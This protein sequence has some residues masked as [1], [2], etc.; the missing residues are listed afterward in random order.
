VTLKIATAF[1]LGSLMFPLAAHAQT[2]AFENIDRLEARLVA[3]LDADIGA[4]GGPMT[5]I[6]RRMKLT[7]CPTPATID[8]PALGAIA[9]RCEAI[10]WRIRVPLQRFAAAQAATVK[11]EPVVRKGDPVELYVETRGFSVSTEAIAQEDGAMGDRI[12][13]K[14]DPKA[15]IMIAEVVDGG[16][17]RLPGYK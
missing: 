17:V 1:T 15:P 9:I 2:A 13:V 6:D 8:P 12:R 16:R 3:A 7:R 11:A 10:G 4:P 5:P 14:S